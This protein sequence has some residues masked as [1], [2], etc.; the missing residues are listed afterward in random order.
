MRTKYRFFSSGDCRRG[1][2]FVAGGLLTVGLAGGAFAETVGGSYSTIDLPSS[3]QSV[4]P[5][6]QTSPVTV[7]GTTSIQVADESIILSN[8]GN[9]F[10]GTV[11]LTGGT[12][13]ITD[14]SSLNL[15]EVSAGSLSA[16]SHGSLNLGQGTVT[17]DL[18]A[19]SNGGA[20]SQS[21]ALSVGGA[22][23][24]NAGSGDIA[25][26]NAGNE[27]GG[28]VTLTGGAVAI[29]DKSSLNLGTVSAGSLSAVSHGSLNL[30]QGTV[31]GDLSASSNGGAISQSG[32]LSVGG[33]S[34]I[35]A[36]V[37]SIALDNASNE[38]GGTVTLTGGAV[39]ITDKS[40]LSLGTVSAGSLS[41]VSHGS[42]NLGQGSVTG[43][44]S[45]S[46]NG[47][48]ILQS[49]ALSVGGA[50][51]IDAGAGSIALD[52]ASND[53]LGS[54][55]VQGTDIKIVDVNDL[56]IASVVNGLNASIVLEAGGKLTL[57]G[58]A[59]NVGTATLSLMSRGG[60]LSTAAA[61]G[62]AQVELS[63]RDGI[64]LNHN[65]AA[66]SSLALHGV[67]GITQSGGAVTAPVVS[68]DSDGDVALASSANAI[69]RLDNVHV[70][71]DFSLNNEV[72]LVINTL[73]ANSVELSVD[74]G[75][76]VTGV[77]ST[78]QLTMNGGRLSVNGAV[79]GNVQVM[80][81]ASLAGVGTVGNTTIRAGGM[82]TPG[83]SIGTL[84]VD[85]DLVFDAGSHYLVEVDPQGTDADLVHVTGTA[86]LAG[87]SVVHI[88]ADGAY[89]PSSTYRILKADGSL[90]GAF[91]KVTSDFAFL[92]PDLAYDYG[93][94]TVDLSLERNEVSFSSMALTGN[95]GATAA[96]IESLGMG[97]AV[98]DAVVTLPDD[99]MQIQAGFDALSGEVYASAKT[100]LV[101]ESRFVRNAVFDRI[102]TAFD[103][104]A[105][106]TMPVQTYGADHT[107]P[108]DRFAAWGHA[109]GSW[110]HT[111]SD[112]N[113][114]R[115]ERSTRGFLVGADG[116]VFDAW[117]AGL[118]AGYSRSSF[119]ATARVSSGESDNYH[120]GLYGGRQWGQLGLR[121]GLAYTWHNIDVN[122]SLAIGSFSDR[123]SS[124]YR[125]GTFQ[126]FGELG[127][128]V[129][130][131]H[132]SFEP[133]VG[134]A[135]INHRTDGYTERGGAAALHSGGQTTDTT[136]MTLGLRGK[137][138]F[139]LGQM[140]ASVYG[141]LGWRH[142]FGDTVPT[143]IHAFS[144][145]DAF[146]V[147]GAPIARNAAV[148]EAGLSLAVASNAVLSLSYMGQ[149]AAD[150][151]DHGARATLSISF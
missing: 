46:S 56:Q 79:T 52:N 137:T 16:V 101:E 1:V 60:T 10:E 61:L 81:G 24:I 111:G 78:G 73:Q 43:D 75:V 23:T 91:E 123:L 107:A 149:L 39:A 15:G 82:L 8:A 117:R 18:S 30:G 83:N 58:H 89:D 6:T 41:A 25:L 106:N 99:A 144:E 69:E 143:S 51:T 72:P 76:N 138:G 26:H 63:G 13:A 109:F 118:V 70:L 21:G 131:P 127:Y 135:Y 140:Q 38:F 150:A 35:D 96:G 3:G 74:A 98:Y 87:G 102:R 5:V 122:R 120:L 119:D 45:A 125:A 57:P 47:G 88:G 132:V 49:G 11:T 136:F 77:V 53:F 62:G 116:Q 66:T 92:T 59:I 31:T 110:G 94:G 55:T 100:A 37:G 7:T 133:F 146:T 130:T 9:E 4:A 145:G 67:G 151:K 112:G 19:S 22:S 97:Q 71:G 139:T 64:S 114:A 104:M 27:F 17:G 34:T 103:G 115:L 20:I 105:S 126:I 14:K 85:G 134:L 108:T 33:A 12:V 44:L 54:L 128:Q 148:L 65:V 93:A 84:T 113:S 2:G 36:G 141:T 32:A 28:T 95:Q 129:D 147:A 48:A 40:S 90:I 80:A 142:A 42:L 86:S 121:T 124:D 50:S 29:T 68:I